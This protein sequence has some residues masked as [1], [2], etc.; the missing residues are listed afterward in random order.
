[1]LAEDQIATAA[2]DAACDGVPPPQ[3]DDEESSSYSSSSSSSEGDNAPLPLPDL[4]ES[5]GNPVGAHAGGARGQATLPNKKWTSLNCELC[6][7]VCGQYKHL[8]LSDQLI[9]HVPLS[10]GEWPERGPC[11]KRRKVTKGG[12]DTDKCRVEVIQ[13]LQSHRNCCKTG[14]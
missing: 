1:M 8:L 11:Q 13:W 9:F 12:C 14:T 3:Q 6:G 5:V 2:V 7:R 10:A 4:S